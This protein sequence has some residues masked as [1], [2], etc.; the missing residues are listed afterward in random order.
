MDHGVRV[1]HTNSICSHVRFHDI[2]DC[3]VGILVS[4]ITLPLQHRGEYGHRFGAGL[5]HS[6]HRILVIEL[7]HVPAGVFNDID[8][9]PVLYRLNS[10]KGDADF[11][12]ETGQDDLL[13]PGAFDRRDEVLVIPGIHRGPFDRIVVWKDS[14]YL[15]PDIPAEAFRLYR[16]EHDWDIEYLG[17]LRECHC[18]VYDR[19]TIEVADSEQHLR[20]MVNQRDNAVVRSQESFFAEFVT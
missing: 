18:V 7:A 20:L 10:R 6:L 17:S 5:D 16:S 4:P 19:L 8:F 15:G 12:P 1:L 13:A 14:L 3:V 11:S 2:H 9:V